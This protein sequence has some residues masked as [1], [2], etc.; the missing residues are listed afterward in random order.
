[1]EEQLLVLTLQGSCLNAPATELA[2][3]TEC[4]LPRLTK[5]VEGMNPEYPR[6]TGDQARMSMAAA[7][8]GVKMQ[9]L[10]TGGKQGR[11]WKSVEKAKVRKGLA[12]QHP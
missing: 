2:G 3:G 1:M 5:R 6:S 10:A 4:T 11:N 12:G 7:N 9:K 8:R